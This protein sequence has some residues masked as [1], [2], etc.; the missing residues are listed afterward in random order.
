MPKLIETNEAERILNSAFLQRESCNGKFA[1]SIEKIILGKHKTY[2]YILVTS[3]LARSTSDE[4]SPLALQAGADIPG[5]FD[6][7]SLCHQVV[8]PFE[9]DV[10]FNALG[11]SNEPYLNKPARYPMLSYNNAVR[12]GYDRNLLELLIE[13]LSSISSKQEAYS[14]L[15][16][17]FYC[18]DR[19]ILR[20]SKYRG[21]TSSNKPVLVERLSFI[22][23]LLTKSCQGEIPVI[24]VGTLETLYHDHLDSNYSVIIHKVNQ[25]GSSS[26]EVGDI[27]V[28]DPDGLVYAI[29]VKD[30]NFTEYDIQHAASKIMQAG[31]SQ[32]L[33]I[34]GSGVVFDR[35]EVAKRINDYEG[36]GFMFLISDILK[37]SKDIL[38]RI[39]KSSSSKFID[40]IIAV[41][42]QIN[43][44][45][46]TREWIIENITPHEKT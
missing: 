14:Y 7:R 24:V 28:F 6:A 36:E 42:I 29:E 41:S 18:L 44:T 2:R 9:R 46:T 8:V 43:A 1:A 45:E 16:Y 39:G 4:I 15:K 35:G 40:T 26:K 31:G 13:L 30:K 17:V 23:A 3:L 25:A 19:K 12:R 22:K 37:Y 10:L 32:G 21:F 38:F 20:L 27:D 33:F 11:G 34:Y 5:A